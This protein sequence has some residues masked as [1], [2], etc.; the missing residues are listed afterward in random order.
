VIFLNAFFGVWASLVFGFWM[1]V[2][3]D[4]LLANDPRHGLRLVLAFSIFDT[5]EGKRQKITF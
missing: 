3:G 2:I 4:F 1:G 5:I